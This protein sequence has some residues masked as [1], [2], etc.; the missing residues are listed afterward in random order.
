MLTSSYSR[1][2]I[3]QDRH[4]IFI[5]IASYSVA[6]TQY[7]RGTRGQHPAYLTLYEYGP[8]QIKSRSHMAHFGRL[9]V[10]FCMAISDDE[11]KNLDIPMPEA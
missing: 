11:R 3:S 9:I 1:M 7:L 5:T 2:L 8:W 6:Y 10:E 4:E